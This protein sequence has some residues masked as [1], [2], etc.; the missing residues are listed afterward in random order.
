MIKLFSS[1]AFKFFINS[2]KFSNYSF[3]KFQLC[4][5]STQSTPNSPYISKLN[6]S[7]FQQ[8]AS[9][10]E[11]VPEEKLR[12]LE[13][14]FKQYI[15]NRDPTV[16]S[17]VDA[18]NL[19]I[20]IWR[21]GSL[22]QKEQNYSEAE[23][24]YLEALD[25]LRKHKGKSPEVI[26]RI[27]NNLGGLYYE[28]NQF[29]KAL[30]CLKNVASL[31]EAA[32]NVHG[33]DSIK[34]QNLHLTS[35]VLLGQGKEDE[36]IEPLNKIISLVKENHHAAPH[37][38]MMATIFDSLGLIYRRKEDFEKAAE[39][40]EEG[41][42]VM[43]ELYSEDVDGLQDLYRSVAEVYMQQEDD[44]KEAE[45]LKKCIEIS[46][47][48]S[49]V[50]VND[51]C[52]LSLAQFHSG[53]YKEFFENA[54]KYLENSE[55]NLDLEKKGFVLKKMFVV[56]CMQNEMDLAEKCFES[57]ITIL[58]EVYGENSA[59]IAEAHLE[60]VEAYCAVGRYEEGLRYTDKI[61]ALYEASNA[62]SDKIEQLDEY[63]NELRELIKSKT[64]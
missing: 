51:Y 10:L 50:D 12:L 11:K 44:L 62:S 48:H 1:S 26:I 56:H 52:M 38:H 24:Y 18:R 43:K 20:A 61:K 7:S 2:S 40:W 47:K 34:V 30:I 28:M 45:S 17:D 55:S 4:S 22:A 29:E 13:N 16:L 5:F 27:Q 36:A 14:I 49:K 42:K 63:I 3:L 59:E 58:Q 9:N 37:A 64:Q 35:Q 6:E 54:R 32:Q 46:E 33:F 60:R 23:A 57:L 39:I 21:M 25:I 31:L 8:I 53:E 41:I 15:A 19:A